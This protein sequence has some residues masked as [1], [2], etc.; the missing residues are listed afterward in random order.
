M[1]Q[2]DAIPLHLL[3]LVSPSLPVGAFAY[4]RALE[5]AVHAGWV[6][7][8]V[9]ARDWIIGGLEHIFA[10][11][12]GALF[13]RM[14][15]ALY[16]EDHAGF[17]YANA[18]LAACR[19]SREMQLEDRR[20][21]EALMSLLK[22]LEVPAAQN[23]ACSGLTYPASFA[24][25]A[26]R[27]HIAPLPALKGLMWTVADAQVA[28]AIRLVPLGHVMGQRILIEA[29]PVVERSAAWAT[30]LDD[31]DIGNLSPAQAMASAWHETQYSRLF[32]S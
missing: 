31:D 5:G 6:Q 15:Q 4:S 19:E 29:V 26:H 21:A 3:R 22:A 11:T 20:M 13:W 9:T 32:R 28:A 7:D 25:A 23:H 18:W 10:A 1:D 24:I 2:E 17:T 8:H 16:A 12:D 14:I 30:T 27:W